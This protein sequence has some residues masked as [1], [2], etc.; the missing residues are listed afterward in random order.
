MT[1]SIYHRHMTQRVLSDPHWKVNCTAYCAAMA[2]TDSTLG[3]VAITG[4]QVRAMSDEPTPD[5]SSPGLNLQQVITV[6]RE[7]HVQLTDLST[8]PWSQLIHHIN[9][10]RRA[11]TQVDYASLGAARCQANGDFGHAMLLVG[12]LRNGHILASDPLCAVEKL[13]RE[14]TLRGAAE[15]FARQTGVTGV[16]FAV[17]RSIGRYDA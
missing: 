6:A 2:I 17:T 11:V 10:G 12:P 15:A 5:Q 13:Y 14:S 4:R 8:Q 9:A 3:G 7:L 1:A 16:R